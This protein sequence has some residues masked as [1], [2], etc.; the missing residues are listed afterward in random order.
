MQI[1]VAAGQGGAPESVP[2][3]Q[4][5][6]RR[7]Q[8]LE[9]AVSRLRRDLAAMPEAAARSPEQRDRIVRLLSEVALFRI[10]LANKTDFSEHHQRTA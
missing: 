3:P 4:D 1:T 8:A 10:A 9:Q 7:V 6:L 2:V 5:A